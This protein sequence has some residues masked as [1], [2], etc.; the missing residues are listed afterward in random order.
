MSNG[1]AGLLECH[2]MA[3]LR[4]WPM[5]EDADIDRLLRAVESRFPGMQVLCVR[6]VKRRCSGEVS[7]L[8][9]RWDRAKLLES[10]VLLPEDLPVA[11]KRVAWKWVGKHKDLVFEVRCASRARFTVRIDLADDTGESAPLAMFRPSTIRRSNEIL[12]A[13]RRPTWF[14][15]VVDNTRRTG[16][17]VAS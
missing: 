15:F 13:K 2:A 12:I 10:G 6:P 14:R 1:T 8:E 7:L 17:E 16:I 11:P 9:V 4:G 5:Y 3:S